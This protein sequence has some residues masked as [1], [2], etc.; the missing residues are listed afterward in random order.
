MADDDDEITM[1]PEEE[2]EPEEA[3]IDPAELDEDELDDE[4]LVEEDEL[5]DPDDDF[6]AVEE[7]EEEE[8]DTSG[9]VRRSVVKDKDKDEEED[10]DDDMLAPDD[11]EADLDTILKDRLVAAEDED[12][13][14]EEEPEE[15]GEAVDRLQPKRADEQLCPSCFLLVRQSAPGCPVGDDDC[16][17]FR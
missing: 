1:E 6:V 4:L 13:N 15:R 9:P 11:V 8:D 16:P 3:E 10:E 7:D 12:E 2:F 5:V 17:L 14:E